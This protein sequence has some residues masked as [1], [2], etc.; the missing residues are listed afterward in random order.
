MNVGIVEV[1]KVIGIKWKGMRYGLDSV[2]SV[3]RS[4]RGSSD[5]GVRM[6]R[7][8]AASIGESTRAASAVAAVEMRTV[9]AGDA[10]ARIEMSGMVEVVKGTRISGSEIPNKAARKLRKKVSRVR[11]RMLCIKVAFVPRHIDKAPLLEERAESAS[12]KE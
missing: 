3:P 10:D 11:A 4:D 7:V 5:E 2:R 1:R 8:L 6:R 12:I 9:A